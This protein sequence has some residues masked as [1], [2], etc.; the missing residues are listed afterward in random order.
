MTAVHQLIRIIADREDRIRA[1]AILQDRRCASGSEHF[2]Y[3]L[4][5]RLDNM[6]VR[7][8][9]Q[10][11]Y[12]ALAYG[13]TREYVTRH[14]RLYSRLPRQVYRHLLPFEGRGIRPDQSLPRDS[15]WQAAATGW[16]Q[17]RLQA[18]TGI[19]D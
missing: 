1:I 19:T 7:T 11:T 3:L 17:G 9:G 10:H 13:N 4:P 18:S 2:I 15:D 12:G 8:F 5:R 6:P 14:G 16:L